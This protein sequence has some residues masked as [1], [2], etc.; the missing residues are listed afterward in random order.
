LR[1]L[2]LRRRLQIANFNTHTETDVSVYSRRRLP[3]WH[4][5]RARTTLN[6][7]NARAKKLLDEL[8]TLSAEDRLLIA[9]E[10]NASLDSPEEVAT[11]WADE[12]RRRADDI[13]HGRAELVDK[14]VALAE[15]RE[16]LR[17]GR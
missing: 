16:R 13:E 5:A 6:V 1:P 7:M 4:V 9:A 11:A 17:A 8:L 10:L 15:I 14:D 12:I 2:Y 3:G